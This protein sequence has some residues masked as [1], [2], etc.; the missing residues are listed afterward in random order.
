MPT[1]REARAIKNILNDFAMV[2]GTEVSLNKSKV[3]SF[4]T[5]IA[6]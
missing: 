1:V 6:I 3:F 5:N 2:A 4:N